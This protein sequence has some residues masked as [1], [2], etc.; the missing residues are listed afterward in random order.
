M[1]MYLGRSRIRANEEISQVGSWVSMSNV[2]R[3]HGIS[4][5]SRHGLM[6][7]TN[8]GSSTLRGAVSQR[9]W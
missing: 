3:K 6:L 7:M 8:K 2:L 9:G 5:Q 4:W 1:N